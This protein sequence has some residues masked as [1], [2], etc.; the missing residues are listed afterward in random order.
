MPIAFDN[1][2]KADADAVSSLESPA[3]LISGSNR[4]LVVGVG[5]IEITTPPDPSSVKRN[6]SGGTNLTQNGSSILFDSSQY[7]GSIWELVAPAA[8]NETIYVALAETCYRVFIIGCSFT[9]VNQIT[10]TRTRTTNNATNE[11]DPGPATVTC[12]NTALNDLVV[13]FLA[14]GQS[15]GT[16]TNVAVGAGQTERAVVESPDLDILAGGMSTEPATGSS[17]TMTW[18]VTA[19]LG[20]HHYAL[21]G[22]PLIPTDVTPLR[23]VSS[24]LR[25]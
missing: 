12:A 11:A 3:W 9:G 23:V 8:A 15:G 5:V 21:F 18:D 1:S 14:C 2:G 7:R 13:D 10:P 4:H 22:L 20:V 17:V 25:W 24:P 19:T 6:G 16:A